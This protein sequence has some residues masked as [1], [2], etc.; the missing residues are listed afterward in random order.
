MI[1]SFATGASFALGVCIVAVAYQLAKSS[2]DVE[3]STKIFAP[4]EL[5]ILE[6]ALVPDREK[7]TVR[8]VIENKGNSVWPFALL[9]LRVYAGDALMSG[10]SIDLSEIEANSRQ[11]FEL[12]CSTTQGRN[13]PDNIS[14][15][16]EIPWGW[17]LD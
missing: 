14:Y 15:V 2:G 5:V 9:K 3:P 11:Q 13:L 17:R 6:H 7:F 16:I 1:I 4:E 12:G 8:G 10:C